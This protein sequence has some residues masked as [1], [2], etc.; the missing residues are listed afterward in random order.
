VEEEEII[1]DGMALYVL[2]TPSNAWNSSIFE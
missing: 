1:V 2:A